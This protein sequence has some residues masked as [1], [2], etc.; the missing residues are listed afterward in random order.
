MGCIYEARNV[1]NGKRYIG[2]SANGLESRKREH[3][4]DMKNG[5]K[6][7]FHCALRKYGLAVFRWKMLLTSDDPDDL[8]SL[9]RALISILKTKAPNG[10][11]LTDGG[12]GQRGWNPSNETREKIRAF[13]IGRKQPTRKPEHCRKLSLA[14]R[15]K[16]KSDLHRQRLS[17]ARRG[18]KFGTL[19]EATRQKI[20]IANTGRI[21]TEAAKAKIKAAN[22]GRKASIETRKKMPA[23]QIR[24]FQS[25]KEREAVRQRMYGNTHAQGYKHT[26][27][28]KEKISK[29]HS[30][31]KQSPEHVARKVA[32]Y[33]EA[34]QKRRLLARD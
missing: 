26:A 7:V 27:E 23:S 24:R 4:K 30:G 15:G 28:A 34:C 21:C 11:N 33:K 19:S 13:L 22:I 32:S 2:K 16:P 5:S 1:V 8:C 12:D 14:L 25:V 9:E 6:L 31:H 29:T 17:D 10:Y 3:L 18:R 20:G